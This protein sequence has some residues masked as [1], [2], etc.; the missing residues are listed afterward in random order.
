MNMPN[1]SMYQA[2]MPMGAVPH[3]DPAGVPMHGVAVPHTEAMPGGVHVNSGM[4]VDPFLAAE[5]LLYAKTGVRN[6]AIAITETASPE[7]RAMLQKQLNNGIALHAQAFNYMYQRSYYP[8]YDINRIL[9][10]DCK[11]AHKALHTP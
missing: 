3:F 8:A 2:Q 7:I 11:N 6:T 5:L 4:N 1:H 10:N 9:A